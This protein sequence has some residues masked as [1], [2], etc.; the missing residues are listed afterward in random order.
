MTL[1]QAIR[2]LCEIE[3]AERDEGLAS[4]YNTPPRLGERER[5]EAAICGALLADAVIVDGL[6]WHVGEN[7]L[8]CR[9]LRSSNEPLELEI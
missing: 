8:V 2:R 9:T 5:L 3:A 7:G 6:V 4:Q 1:E